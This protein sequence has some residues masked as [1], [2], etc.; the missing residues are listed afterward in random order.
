MDGENSDSSCGFSR[1]VH[2]AFLSLPSGN[3]TADQYAWTTLHRPD[4]SRLARRIGPRGG[5]VRRPLRNRLCSDGHCA[6]TP[7]TR[8]APAIW[9]APATWPDRHRSAGQSTRCGMDRIAH[10]SRCDGTG[11]RGLPIPFRS[12]GSRLERS[13]PMADAADACQGRRVARADRLERSGQAAPRRDR[14]A[15]RPR[16]QAFGSG[17]TDVPQALGPLEASLVP[18]S[19]Q[20]TCPCSLLGGPRSPSVAG[21]VVAID[22]YRARWDRYARAIGRQN[23][24]R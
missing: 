6:G 4:R 16:S 14:A 19:A 20:R 5:L 2:D 23:A 13:S 24:A 21:M 8:Q 22:P 17:R 18:T 9:P 10:R 3:S 11:R 7:A 15:S 12:L 1:L